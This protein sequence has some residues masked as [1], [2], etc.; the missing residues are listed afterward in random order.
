MGLINDENF[1]ARFYSVKGF[2]LTLQI[3]FSSGG[4]DKGHRGDI[5]V[6]LKLGADRL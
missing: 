5:K 4:D 3:S 6:K 1:T 2:V